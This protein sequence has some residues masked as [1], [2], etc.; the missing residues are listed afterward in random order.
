MSQCCKETSLY[1]FCL[2][3]L[4][5]LAIM[6]KIIHPGLSPG[7][8]GWHLRWDFA[9]FSFLPHFHVPKTYRSL[10]ANITGRNLA[11]PSLTA[12]GHVTWKNRVLVWVDGG[13][14]YGILGRGHRPLAPP[15]RSSYV[16]G[17]ARCYLFSPVKPP[18]TRGNIFSSGETP[19]ALTS[20]H[21]GTAS[22]T[23]KD[24]G[25]EMTESY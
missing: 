17:L 3:L 4:S 18:V 21:S 7:G 16:T 19:T 25:G 5:Y 24:R 8:T 20:S 14:R 2:H 10:C 15:H 11:L 13:M 9:V 12:T 22:T 23:Q 1:P 6:C